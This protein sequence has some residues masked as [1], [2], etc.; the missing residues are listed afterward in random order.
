MTNDQVAMMIAAHDKKIAEV[1]MLLAENAKQLAETRRQSEATDRK[2]ERLIGKWGIFVENVIAPGIPRVFQERKIEI[3]HVSNR[4]KA[5]KNGKQMEI[6]I[7]G[8]NGE[9]VVAV[10]VKSTLGVDD[11]EE[12]LDD[13]AH[14]KEFFP[15]YADKKLLGAVAGIEI[16]GKADRFAYQNG[17]FV[18]GQSGDMAVCLNDS[19]FKPKEW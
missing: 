11:V 5:K 6:D 4:N 12:H 17:L 19:N 8:K 18:I 3:T 13:L 14:F 2:L 15:D 1:W 16:V 10:S 7:I 9:Y